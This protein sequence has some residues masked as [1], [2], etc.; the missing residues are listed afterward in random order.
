MVLIKRLSTFA[1]CAFILCATLLPA[2][3][4]TGA[5]PQ[6]PQLT[7]WR[8]DTS[9]SSPPFTG[10]MSTYTGNPVS[11]TFGGN[12]NAIFTDM[13]WDGTTLYY[14]YSNGTLVSAYNLGSGWRQDDM[15]S[16]GF[17]EAQGDLPLSLMYWL[18]R[19]SVQILDG[20][21]TIP[22]VTWVIG[23]YN[24]PFSR[25][26]RTPSV[27]LNVTSNGAT[28]SFEGRT[29]TW[30]S[31]LPGFEGFSLDNDNT[32]EYLI[33]NSYSLPGGDAIDATKTLYPCYAS[34]PTKTTVVYVYNYDGTQIL[35]RYGVSAEGTSPSLSLRMTIDGFR[36]YSGSTLLDTF[37]VNSNDTAGTFAGFALRPNASFASF[38]NGA[39]VSVGGTASNDTLNLYT[40]YYAPPSHIDDFELGEWLGTAVGGFFD[41][42]LWPN[43][44]LG[45][46][47]LVVL[48]IGL[49]YAFLKM[50]I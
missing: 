5:A 45:D 49:L 23:N 47:L 38:A 25:T 24:Y 44:S 31:D 21:T 15:R 43:F 3:A 33:G 39:T 2:F 7:A 12:P 32:P 18:F 16:I 46:I 34:L 22:V 17:T 9:I 35:F 30:T 20:T 26:N 6:E 14:H 8:F 11:F 19:N 36:L 29:F 40:F 28:L 27:D 41:F 10:Y 50:T 42:Q 4:V 13:Y 48:S 1:V 37:S